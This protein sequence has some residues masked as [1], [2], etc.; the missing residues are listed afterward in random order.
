MTERRKQ[1]DRRNFESHNDAR[2]RCQR[3]VSPDRRLNSIS[4]EWIPFS[5]VHSHPDARFVFSRS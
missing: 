3:R 4:V 2:P 1:P 5:N